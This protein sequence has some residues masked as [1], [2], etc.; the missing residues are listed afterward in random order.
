[1]DKPQ[2]RVLLVEDTQAQAELIAEM[3]A[4]VREP[5]YELRHVTRLEEALAEARTREFDVV[6]LDLKL[7][8]SE[9]PPGVERLR[10]ELPDVP[11]IVLTNVEDEST[12]E[13]CVR[14]GAED[15][16]VKRE[17]NPRLLSRS[18]RYALERMKAEKALRESEQRYA[19]A[20]AGANDGLWD[21]DLVR[22]RAY[23]SPRWKA[24]LGYAENEIGDSIDEWFLRVH[25]DDRTSFRSTLSAHLEGKTSHFEHE[26]RLRTRDGRDLWVLCR[27][28]AVRDQEGQTV[29][30]A[31]SLTDISQRK[32]AEEQ[33]M[34]D[35]LH[36]ALTRLPNRTLFMDRL[37]L[38]LKRYRRDQSK[39]FA[40]LFFDLDRFKN[41]NDSL[42]H[43]IG[44]E[45]LVSVAR[46]VEKSLRPGD[47]LARL[48]G[49]EFAILITD[50]T[51]TVHATHLAERV[52]DLLK[53]VFLI[54]EHE[55]Y[56]SASVGIAL[57]A[58]HYQRPEE[59]LRDADLAMYRAKTI[60][61]A[62]Y[63]VFDSAMHE[64]AVAL[65]RLEMDL[66]RA[67]ERD[68][69]VV[70]YQPI[71]SLD[72]DRILGF[73]AL[74]RWEHPQWGLVAPDYFIHVAEETG[75][76]VPLG[77]WVLHESCAQTRRWQELFPLDPPLSI[78]VNVSGKL[79]VQ[80]D[81]IAQV[82]WILE[83]TGLSASSL[84]LEITESA[85]MSHGVKSLGALE[86]LRALGVQLHIDDFGTGYSSLSYLQRFSY[87]SIKID[88]SF[89]GSL[90]CREDG[91][92]IVGAIIALGNSLGMKVIAEGVE[93]PEQLETLRS[94]H[95]PEGQGYWFSKPLDQRAVNELL[96]ETLGAIH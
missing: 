70:H 11:V 77:W 20:V 74:L 35:A 47:T 17:V 59:V 79:I 96:N 63:A 50:V 10:A 13:A 40:V 91:N 62:S 46:R 88:R 7:P 94:M 8:D 28:L 56:T 48:G 4:S 19:L 45:L 22:D 60:G 53:E 42:G 2:L 54:R 90:D 24:I 83:K 72:T 81:L 52:H 65:H 84:R 16:L 51:E 31:G 25:E 82:Q 80:P 92:A 87:D 3:L 37:D 36:D 30:I 26:H 66:R 86:S 75:L 61:H 64:S 44:D 32:H 78:S 29:R 34:H 68:E 95:C 12:G 33:L 71:V 85:I 9:G 93:T 89:V 41:I 27:G 73:E 43:M 76:I 57:A 69:F 67:V 5:I 21:W 58:P 18:I 6:L 55:I 49:D 14:D 15:Y 1:M 38:A 39:L 23:F